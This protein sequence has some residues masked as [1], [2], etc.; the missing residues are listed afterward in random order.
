MTNDES[1]IMLVRNIQYDDIVKNR[2]P[3][4]NSIYDVA[5]S[6]RGNYIYVNNNYDLIQTPPDPTIINKYKGKMNI[7]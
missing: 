5:M 4:F 3:N 6:N 2:Y 1:F 7:R